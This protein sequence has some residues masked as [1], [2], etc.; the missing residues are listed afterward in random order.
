MREGLAEPFVQGVDAENVAVENLPLLGRR[1][2]GRVALGNVAVHV[3]LNVVNLGFL[4][5][6]G[7]Q[8]VNVVDH[9]WAG[10]VEHVLAPPL[11]H[12]PARGGQQV[13]GVVA[14]E[15]G[16]E[17]GH[18]RLEP[19]AK[20]HPP[21]VNLLAQV[22]QAVGELGRVRPPVAQAGGFSRSLAKPAVVE[23]EELHP[24]CLSFVGQAQQLVLGEVEVG[25]FPVV[26]HHRPRLVPP[27]APNQVLVVEL[28]EG[29][30]EMV[31]ATFRVSQHRFR[32][33]EAFAGLELPGEVE[34]V[35]ADLQAGDVVV[36]DL[37]L[38]EEVA[39]VN[40]AHGQRLALEVVGVGA[41]EDYEGV[42]YVAR[43]PAGGGDGLLALVEA[44]GLQ[45]PLPPPGPGEL[46]PVVVGV[47]QVEVEAE[48]PGELRAGGAAVN[49]AGVAGDYG[50]ILEDGV[51][52]LEVDGQ[53]LV[54]Q[55]DR[56]GFGFLV[57]LNV[58]GW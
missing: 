33:L 8:L 20:Q 13:V 50:E 49:E 2:G 3:P 23:D 57:V 34:G 43:G 53:L 21:V 27:L 5:D 18:F 36:V 24:G 29:L 35:N 7:R 26:N 12:S 15:V 32:G 22:G 56:Q 14:V 39:G 9:L 55:G 30:A 4:Q 51:G 46:E 44:V 37:G 40:E 17:V 52:E 6:L 19:E 16:V 58:G 47:R 1:E 10:K 42:L 48:R 38:G 45:L 31:Q 25:R 28:V 11:A 54:G 41:L